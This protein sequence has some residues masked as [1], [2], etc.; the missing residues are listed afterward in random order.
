MWTN[1]LVLRD[2][3]LSNNPSCR[4]HLLLGTGP[5]CLIKYPQYLIESCPI[6]TLIPIL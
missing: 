2:F 3:S 1:L 6:V 4:L 5:R